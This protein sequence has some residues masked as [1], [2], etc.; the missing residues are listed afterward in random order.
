MIATILDRYPTPA[1]ALLLGLDILET[2]V[3]EGWVRIAFDGKRDFCN[4]SGAIQGG[5][6]SAMLDDAMGV[7][8]LIATDAELHPTTI[9]MNVSFLS[10]ARPGPLFGKGRV[11]QLGKTI[12][13]VE[14]MLTNNEELVIAQA[15]SSVRLRP[16]PAALMEA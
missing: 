10:P 14:A 8:I 11:V 4:A 2:D 16:M 5:F 1:C 15:T 3:A 12:G 6:L 9:H 13:F 7:A